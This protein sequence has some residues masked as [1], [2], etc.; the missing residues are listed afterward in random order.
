MVLFKTSDHIQIRNK[1][2]IPSQESQKK[3]SGLN[4]HGYS[5]HLQNQAREPKFRTLVY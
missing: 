3:Q 2:P 1:M 4:G 5:L